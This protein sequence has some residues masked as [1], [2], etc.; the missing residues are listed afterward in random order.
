M[1]KCRRNDAGSVVF[2]RVS[3]STSTAAAGHFRLCTSFS[4]ASFRRK[5][6]DAVSCGGSSRYRYHHDG[7]GGDDT[8]A[9]AIRSV[10]D[11]VKE[12]QA[13]KP[14][15][16]NAKSEKLLDLLRLESPE[17]EPETRKKEEV[18]EEFKRA[19]KK[20][21]DEDL[22]KR[23]AAASRVRFLA[24]E[25]A[26]ARGTLALLGA[27]PPLVGMLDLEDDESK[28]ASLYALLNLGI[29]ND[30]YVFP[31]RILQFDL[32]YCSLVLYLLD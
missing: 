3:V 14:T 12:R 23:R 20:L 15:R 31:F 2:D 8:V 17:S 21:Q 5:I 22:G 28:I 7:G 26:E 1:A 30:M 10:S 13:A 24:K 18:L 32:F 27:I 6:F 29:G 25:D 19:V 11:I 4:A 9:S 16:S